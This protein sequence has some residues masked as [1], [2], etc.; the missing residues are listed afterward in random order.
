MT[1]KNPI[2]I[3]WFRRDLRINDNKGF[4]K[5]LSSGFRVLPL[6]IFDKNIHDRFDTQKDLRKEFIHGAI[7]ALQKELINAGSSLLIFHDTPEERIRKVITEFEVKAVYANRDCE[8]Y[9]IQRDSRIEQILRESG[10]PF[11]TFRDQVLFE[12]DDILKPDGTPYTI[13]TPY[14]RTW[15]KHLD[16]DRTRCFSSEKLLHNLLKMNP[17]PLPSP[18]EPGFDSGGKTW[19]V[20]FIDHEI[21]K[22]YH[23]TRDIPS[24][25]GTTKLGVHLCF[26]TVSIRELVRTAI[27]LNEVWLNELIWREFFMSILGHFPRVT[28]N[29]FKRRYDEICWRNNEEEFIRWC[30]GMTGFPIVDAGMR[31]LNETGFMHNRLRM[32]TA[33]FLTKDLLIDWRW[34][35]SYF[36]GK[37]LD[38][39]LSSNNGNWQWAAG[40]GCDAVPYFRVFSP[41]EQTRKFDPA[42]TY[43]S[44]WVPEVNTPSYPQPIADHSI[45]RDRAVKTYREALQK[46][47]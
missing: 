42:L 3:Y 9:A 45:A 10:I 41:S 12:K 14:S 18:A 20:P 21:I 30:N 13:F 46:G 16:D 27:V 44:R 40:C 7:E 1:D 36:A 28:D 31:E 22:N 6:F 17:Q 4:Y 5:A 24:L 38:Y 47:G 11:H 43:I 23:K 15:K 34:G 39:E 2:V 19:V 29:S 32:I 37:L 8:P 33:S 35:E 25:N 26:G